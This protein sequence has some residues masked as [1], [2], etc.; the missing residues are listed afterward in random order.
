MG[1]AGCRV[2]LPHEE[3]PGSTNAELIEHIAEM[4]Y[5]SA[6]AAYRAL[7]ILRTNEVF[8]GDFDS[9]KA[10]MSDQDVSGDLQAN[11]CPDRQELCRAIVRACDISPGLNYRLTGLGRYALRDLQYQRIVRTQNDYGPI[12]GG[13]FLGILARAEEYMRER[14]PDVPGADLGT[15][16][17]R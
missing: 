6:D 3:I 1:L 16:P 4:P 2:T 12:S 5:V 11:E 10:A 13:E 17:G 15:E 9:L 7:H 14:H 8:E